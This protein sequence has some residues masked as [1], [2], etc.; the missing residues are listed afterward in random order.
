MER[1]KH[2]KIN[3]LSKINTSGMS[4]VHEKSYIVFKKKSMRMMQEEWHFPQLLLSATDVIYNTTPRGTAN[5]RQCNIIPPSLEISSS[6][7]GYLWDKRP[8]VCR[9]HTALYRTTRSVSA[10]A[11]EKNIYK[12][13]YTLFK[14]EKY[15]YSLHTHTH[16]LI[17]MVYGDSP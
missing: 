8:T 17:F 1:A 10:C 14:L 2:V 11:I 13:I 9:L 7:R 3:T 6:I 15:I 16:M 12:E 4:Q 5:T